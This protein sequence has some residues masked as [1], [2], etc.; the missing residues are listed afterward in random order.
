M[1]RK[2]SPILFRGRSPWRGVSH[3]LLERTNQVIRRITLR[4]PCGDGVSKDA[5]REGPSPMRRFTTPRFR[6]PQ[7]PQQQRAQSLSV[8]G[9]C[10]WRPCP[11]RSGRAFALH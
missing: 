10:L 7:R 2:R 1:D 8:M 9:A 6:L 3:G 5:T 11:S 4:P